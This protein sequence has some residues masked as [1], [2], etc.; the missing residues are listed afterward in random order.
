MSSNGNGVAKHYDRLTV[1]ERLALLTAAMARGDRVEAGRLSD[2]APQRRYLMAHHSYKFLVYTTLALTHR[3]EL[4]DLAALLIRM[5]GMADVMDAAGSHDHA[6]RVNAAAEFVGFMYTVEREAWRLFCEKVGT[7][8][9]AY[10]GCLAGAD[11]LAHAD[12]LVGGWAFTAAQAAAY[13]REE[14]GEDPVPV[15]TAE[16]KAAEW[17]GLWRDTLRAEELTDG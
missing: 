16:G 2:A 1:R 12:R 4:L 8:P 7:H 6:E 13:V 9:D 11:T 10:G 17:Y 3:I 5:V 15:P 14:R